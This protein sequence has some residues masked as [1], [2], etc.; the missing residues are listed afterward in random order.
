[1]SDIDEILEAV[2]SDKKLRN[3][4][5]CREKIYSDQPLIKRG[6]QIKSPETPQKIKDM[7]AIAYTPEAYW[8]TSAW[9]F[10]T[11]G[12]FMAD[13]TDVYEY[14]D[15]FSNI[16]PTY[17]GLTIQ[18][19]RGY[20]SWR[21]RLRNGETPTAPLPFIYMY[22]YEMINKIGV[23]SSQSGF[24][25]LL[26]LYENYGGL[27][28]ELNKLLSQWLSDYAIYYRLENEY[29]QKCPEFILDGHMLKLMH[30]ESSANDEIFSAI[31]KFSP[32][33]I[34]TSLLYSADPE[35]FKLAVVR[36]Y[37]SLSDY[38]KL[39]RKKSLF[40]NY[41]GTM[42]TRPIRF[43]VN[44]VF[45]DKA[46]NGDIEFEINEIRRFSCKNNA[47]LCCGY[48]DKKRLSRQLGEFVRAVDSLMREHIDFE[49]K[50]TAFPISKNTAA[51]IKKEFAAIDDERR[52]KEAAEVKIDLSRLS[53]I[54]A[55][56]DE[57][58]D[59]L[60]TEDD[61][62]ELEAANEIAETEEITVPEDNESQE[63]QLLTE[64]EK[65]FLTALIYGEGFTEAAKKYGSVP[66]LMTDSINEKLFDIFA[67]TVIGFS[68]GN[69]EI[70]EDYI[71]DIQAM[72]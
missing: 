59:S 26:S 56:A 21:S 67:D 17:A 10:Y 69:P 11:Q 8:K 5:S 63:A 15:K 39:H 9:L 44:S 12:C 71:D 3:S 37:R 27:D 50:I 72:I 41:F 29:I 43:F 32:Y 24:L 38:F 19:L 51:L 1:M 45:Y 55:E 60:L 57:T 49:Q 23:A 6:S 42:T 66:S 48:N 46:K 64:G 58:R 34:S 53:S 40:E 4:K 14:N 52:R 68:S 22:A 54:R 47:W 36:S 33:D 13:F 2:L 30:Y 65:A 16:F 62:A 70:I 28:C 20:F 18:Q 31:M 61:L 7:K 25:K 35:G